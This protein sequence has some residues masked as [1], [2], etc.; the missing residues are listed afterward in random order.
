MQES[1]SAEIKA[2]SEHLNVIYKDKTTDTPPSGLDLFSHPPAPA[3][4][5]QPAEDPLQQAV[6]SAK[7]TAL[8]TPSDLTP[9]AGSAEIALSS[10]GQAES[11]KEKLAQEAL[12]ANPAEMRKLFTT[13]Y[14]DVSV[15]HNDHLD[16]YEI[17][18]GLQ[19]T[20]LP[21]DE[22]NFLTVLKAGYKDF[23]Y[24]P[25]SKLANKTGVLDLDDEGVSAGSL[26]V[27]DKAINRGIN[28]DPYFAYQSKLDFAIDFIGGGLLGLYW[29]REDGGGAK[30]M[31]ISAGFYAV[32][33][34][35]IG[36]GLLLHK[37]HDGFEDQMYD[38]VKN[39]YQSFVKDYEKTPAG[40]K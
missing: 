4:R 22:N 2:F 8:S 31:M 29:G 36:E 11:A 32:A 27:L 12:L 34:T 33:A 19:R 6:G 25:K 38:S 26:A 17:N 5:P 21:E 28:E 20:D 15:N 3:G 18:Q 7:P 9:P 24:D 13:V 30:T 10:A 35:A 16:L 39:D 23:S 37:K 40:H 1:D 14:K